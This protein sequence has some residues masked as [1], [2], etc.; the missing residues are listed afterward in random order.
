[1]LVV[2]ISAK[3]K[4]SMYNDDD[5][6]RGLLEPPIHDMLDVKFRGD[7]HSINLPYCEVANGNF[8]SLAND[9]VEIVVTKDGKVETVAMTFADF[10]KVI[11][12]TFDLKEVTAL[13]AQL[14]GSYDPVKIL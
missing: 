6:D 8:K 14:A 12:T 2:S 1:M 5:D 7:S 10:V 3:L 13:S 4:S 11:E 9:T